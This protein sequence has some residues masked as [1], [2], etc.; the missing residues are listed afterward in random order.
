MSPS[1][2]LD[3]YRPVLQSEN[4]SLES[5][6]CVWMIADSGRNV[7]VAQ[8]QECPAPPLF[9]VCVYTCLS[10]NPLPSGS[11]KSHICGDIKMPVSMTVVTSHINCFSAMGAGTNNSARHTA[12]W[13]QGP[14]NPRC[15]LS[16]LFSHYMAMQTHSYQDTKS[17]L[18]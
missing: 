15:P 1:Q 8:P 9:C 18:P 16:S 10:K 4:S 17:T 7:Q 6:S 2:G 14:K 13:W 5:G 3:T 11:A 12:I